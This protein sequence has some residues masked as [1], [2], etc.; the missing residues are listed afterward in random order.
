MSRLRARCVS[1]IQTW[2]FDPLRGYY[3]E[4]FQGVTDGRFDLHYIRGE[5]L[6]TRSITSS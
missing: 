5:L 3:S 6:P 2:L 4:S 1:G